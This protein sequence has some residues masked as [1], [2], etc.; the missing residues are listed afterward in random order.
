MDKRLYLDVN[1][2]AMRTTWAHGV[3]GFFARPLAL[4]LFAVLVLVALFRS[5]AVGLRGSDPDR[6]AALVWAP[7]GTGIAF[8]VSLPVIH[9]V[10]RARP[11]VAIPQAAVLVPRPGGFSFPSE[12]TVVA[13][14]LTAALWLSRHY[15]IAALAT[16]VSLLMAF[17]VVYTGIAYPGDSLGGL[18]IGSLVS[19]ALYPFAITLLREVVHS[20]ARSPLKLVVEGGR[21]DRAAG[22]G[23]A[24][25]PEPVGQ[26]G[27]V[28]ILGPDEVGAI[29]KVRAI[30]DE[31][32]GPGSPR[33]PAEPGESRQAEGNA[34]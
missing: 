3:L 20:I 4:V 22:P 11:F 25:H 1:R 23:P 29:G 12:Q 18:L 5:R 15:L 9:L 24:A 21:N 16:V 14:A 19:L 17:A 34:L 31:G 30:P 32:A 13:G 7:V 27:G 26:S 2:F 33:A 10:A 28:R 8:L 6:V